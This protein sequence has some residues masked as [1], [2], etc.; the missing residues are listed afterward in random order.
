MSNRIYVL[1]ECRKYSGEIP[2]GY[3]WSKEAAEEWVFRNEEYRYFETV[4]EMST[5]A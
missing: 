1:F 3:T 2:V 5:S 4:E